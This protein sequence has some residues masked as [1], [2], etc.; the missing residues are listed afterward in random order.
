MIQR[1]IHNAR[2][3]VFESA[4][5][6]HFMLL[7]I[8]YYFII[9][10]FWRKI[11]LVYFDDDLIVFKIIEGVIFGAAYTVILISTLYIRKKINRVILYSWVGF[12]LI[13]FYNELF[14]SLNNSGC[15]FYESLLGGNAYFH[16]KITMPLILWGVLS[17]LIDFK[18]YGEIFLNNIESI[19]I[20]NG[21][22]I[23]TGSIF[24]IELFKSYPN[25]DRWGYDGIIGLHNTINNIFYGLILIHTIM[26]KKKSLFK[27]FFFVI[28][29]T[30]LGQ[31]AG[32]LYILLI[33]TAF[34]M[35]IKLMLII[36]GVGL[37]LSYFC[38]PFVS[39]LSPFWKNVYEDHGALGVLTSLRNENIIAVLDSSEGTIN[40]LNWLVGGI[41]RFPQNIEMMFVD[42][43][44][45][46]GAFGVV[47]ISVFIQ[48]QIKT[49]LLSVPLI[50]SFFAGGLY[51]APLG[52]IVYGV[53]VINYNKYN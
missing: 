52:M 13:F 50:V 12:N 21:V 4:R 2:V 42:I 45:F 17:A 15:Y 9:N 6:Y 48:N 14:F 10:R 38:M 39:S 46:Y 36:W 41:I 34:T 30:L 16:F 7:T 32:I 53:I 27:I 5:F 25:S 19:L 3:N 26:N 49:F 18:K 43:L 35:R 31:K 22:L 47:L 24:G 51:E 29:L 20:V 37:I 28:C 23:I 44:F 33:M 1:L 40:I 8:L 11:S